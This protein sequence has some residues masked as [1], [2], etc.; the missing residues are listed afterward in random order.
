MKTKL[1]WNGPAI[2]AQ[3][4]AAAARGLGKAAEH[5]LGEAR[6]EVPHEEGTLERSGVASVEDATLTAAVSFDTKYAVVQHEDM[7]FQ[8]DEGRKA[9][10]LEDPMNREGPTA[11]AIVATEIR[12]SLR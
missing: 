8:H 6:K 3:T 1:K 12:R 9:K 4:S 7:T 10:Y 11:L 5:V 2:T